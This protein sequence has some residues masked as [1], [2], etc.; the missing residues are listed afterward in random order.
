MSDSLRPLLL[1]HARHTPDDSALWSEAVRRG[2][3]TERIRERDLSCVAGRQHVRYYGNVLHASQLEAELPFTFTPVP[4]SFL[5]EAAQAGLTGRRVERLLFKDLRLPIEQPTFV[6]STGIKW[7]ES[8]VYQA[9]ESI[10]GP[11]PEDEIYLQPP[12]RFDAEVRCFVLDGVVQTAS[13]YRVEGQFKPSWFGDSS[14][15]IFGDL[16]TTITQT[17]PLPRGVVI[18]F[19]WL[20]G[21]WV[22]LEANEAWASGLYDCDPAKVFD[23]VEASQVDRPN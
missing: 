20:D 6:K 17:Y 1:L 3:N 14:A 18:D 4:S 2:W 22:L 11:M 13:Y 16:T 19:G 8:R 10:V 15:E 12:V 23:V 9:G 5:D 7:L 21:K